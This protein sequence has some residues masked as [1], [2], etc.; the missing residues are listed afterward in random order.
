MRVFRPGQ[1]GT[2]EARL[3]ASPR[4]ALVRLA[5]EMLELLD[6]SSDNSAP[7]D[8][9]VQR[10]IPDAY[11]HD[12]EASDEFRRLTQDE[13]LDAKRDHARAIREAF[14]TESREIVLDA[15]AAQSV[16]RGLTDLRLM[17]AER[18]DI[19]EDGDEGRTDS[20]SAFAQQLYWL[21]GA[22]QE[23]LVAALVR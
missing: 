16:L 9:A 5:T 15:P 1:S 14:A 10:L 18:L 17:I 6:A 13:V 8:P 11:P 23:D 12:P 4:G 19:H 21:L 3:D 22:L 7:L 2:I 20:E